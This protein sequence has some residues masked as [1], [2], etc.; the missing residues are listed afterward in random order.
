MDEPKPEPEKKPYDGPHA[1]QLAQIL[2]MG[3]A[4]EEIIIDILNST[5]G[6]LDTTIERLLGLGIGL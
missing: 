6:D 2:E 4:G 3:F 5:G 1:L